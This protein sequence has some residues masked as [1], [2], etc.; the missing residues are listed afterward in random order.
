MKIALDIRASLEE[1]A[2]AYFDKAKKARSKIAGAQKAVDL[3]KE[4]KAKGTTVV[5]TKKAP[6]KI[7][8]KAWYEKFKWFYTSDNRLVIAGRDATTNEILIK[9]YTDEQDIVFHT[10]APGSPF[11]VL[12]T[13]GKE[14]PEHILQEVADFTGCHSKAWKLGLSD[15]EVYWVKP[16]QVTKEAKAGEF[17]GRG[18]FMV[19]GKRNFAHPKMNL[20]AI[21]HG[22]TVMVAPL[23]SVQNAEL[24]DQKFVKISQ[25]T[26]KAS[27]T[28]KKVVAL[29][30]FGEVDDVIAGLP[31]GGCRIQK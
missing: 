3:A 19:Y 25:G 1:N 7:R 22:E 30:G 11:V 20:A 16:E 2:A 9:K 12:K 23:S 18:S 15:A 28:A 10:S 21:R 14:V 29:L 4:K 27:E 5:L 26:I 6:K 17:M 8:K 24:S 31:S 13:E